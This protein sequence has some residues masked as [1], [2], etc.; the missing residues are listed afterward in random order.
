[1]RVMKCTKS[2]PNVAAGTTIKTKNQKKKK[3]P[4]KSQLIKQ[5][6][7]LW[8]QCI[9]TIYDSCIIC[10]S[11][12]SLNAH[13]VFSRRYFATRFDT[14]NGVLLCYPHH[15]HLAHSKFEEFRDKILELFGQ[16]KYEELK[17]KSQEIKKWTVE[18]I[19]D[20]IKELE[21]IRDKG[22]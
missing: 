17:N 21:K 15:I 10:G 4:T 22:D 7:R 16:N 2:A 6:D 12:K 9:R 11:T 8:S 1:M 5:A 13:H 3:Q 14:D 19:Q 20:L 18:E